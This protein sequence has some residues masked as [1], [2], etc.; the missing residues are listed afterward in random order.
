MCVGFVFV[1]VYVF[2]QRMTYTSETMGL[3]SWNYFVTRWVFHQLHEFTS[4]HD[5]LML[6]TDLYDLAVILG[7]DFC[8]STGWKWNSG[9][10]LGMDFGLFLVLSSSSKLISYCW[11]PRAATKIAAQSGWF[12]TME[13]YCL[14]DLE[15]RNPR[16]NYQQGIWNVLERNP[17]LILLVCR[18]LR[19]SLV[20]DSVVILAVWGICCSV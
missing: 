7:K 2:Q 14:M 5:S 16:P 3:C 11:L 19:H 4:Y 9:P 10:C 13:I 20:C 8:S 6:R 17:S 1:C 18:S 15:A 12:I